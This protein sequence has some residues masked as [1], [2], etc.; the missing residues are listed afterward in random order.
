RVPAT[1]D[2]PTL[3]LHDALPI[4]R[5]VRVLPGRHVVN[6]V[7]FVGLG[8]GHVHAGHVGGHSLRSLP[9]WRNRRLLRFLP[10]HGRRVEWQESQR[11]EEHTSELQ[12]QSNLVCRLL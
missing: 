8:I 5:I 12:S 2:T 9:S 3:S 4:L 10:L 6:G 11:S 1:P 7:S